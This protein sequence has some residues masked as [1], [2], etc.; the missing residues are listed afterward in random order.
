MSPS[1]T[2]TA[3][4]TSSK[5]SG[6]VVP[7]IDFSKFRSENKTE[8]HQ[9]AGELFSAFKEAGFVYLQNHGL[10]QE[11][12]DE[13]FEWVSFY[14]H[15]RQVSTPLT[16]DTERQVLQSSPVHQRQSPTPP[17]RMVAPRLLG[18]RPRESL[19]DGLRQ[20]LDRRT[21]QDPRRQRVLRDGQREQ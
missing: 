6:S 9:A 20:R 15:Q 3:L 4:P 8:S 17:R 13:A 16:R 10:P 19:S 1:A 11:I 7:L 12:V 2:D 18:S 21:A 14:S 5:P